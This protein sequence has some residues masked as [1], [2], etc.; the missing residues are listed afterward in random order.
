MTKP[1]LNLDPDH[2]SDFLNEP[3]IESSTP[4]VTQLIPP[5]P[6]RMAIT[7]DDVVPY[8]RNPRHKINP[9]Y[10]SIKESI[11]NRGLDDE[12]TIT[13]RSVNE[14]FMICSGGNTRLAI[15]GELYKEYIDL[16]QSAEDADNMDEAQTLRLK[17]NE[18]YH[19]D[20]SYKPWKG[21]TNALIGHMAENEERGDMIYVEK[22]LA[23]KELQ[24]IF[25]KDEKKPLSS[26]KL[27]E[28][29]TQSGWTIGHTSIS[30][31]TYVIT[32]LEPYLGKALWAGLGSPPISKLRTIH[33]AYVKFCESQNISAEK[34]KKIWHEVLTTCDDEELDINNTIRRYAEQ[35]ISDEIGVEFFTVSAEIDAILIGNKK[36]IR[37][38][39][40]NQQ[41]QQHTDKANNVVNFQ[42]S[43]T[44]QSGADSPTPQDNKES[45]TQ[46]KKSLSKPVTAQCLHELQ[47]QVYLKVASL[48]VDFDLAHYIN[49]TA[50]GFGFL[51]KPYEDEQFK[52][53]IDIVDEPEKINCNALWLYLKQLSL[54]D[55]LN[56]QGY[57][58]PTEKAVSGSSLSPDVF[59]TL[60]S[61][62]N[63]MRLTDKNL[64]NELNKIESAIDTLLQATNE[65]HGD[66]AIEQLFN[67]QKTIN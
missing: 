1:K 53:Q 39:P 56:T 6:C 49:K 59:F 64:Q 12:P 40:L 50:T 25:N 34:F 41:E 60:N 52:Y 54:Q 26:R 30:L 61:H 20:W 15:L 9:N 62:F 47:E 29:I 45:N 63:L 35:L 33:R 65:L 7:L 17:A 37:N 2:I 23:V 19:F 55:L 38:V 16:A 13:R 58:I 32:E 18:Y 24:D 3:N 22:A 10:D 44:D 48:S 21:E 36:A 46:Q 4:S 27:A 8:D 66:N 42:P 5:L 57:P 28:K 67:I 11:R 51:I 43:T 14:P 31:M